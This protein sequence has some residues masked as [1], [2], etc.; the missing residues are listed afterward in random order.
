MIEVN[1]DGLCIPNNSEGIPCY[2][3][4]VKRDGRRVHS[5]Y[6]RVPTSYSKE[7]TNNVAEY[8]ALIRS[9]EWLK[10]NGY[11]SENAN[12]PLFQTRSD[13]NPTE[14][15]TIRGDSALI[16][17]QVNMKYKVSKVHLRPLHKRAMSL[18]SQFRNL[19]IIWVPRE[20]NSEADKLSEMAYA[21][22]IMRKRS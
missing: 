11:G 5:E 12:S 15:I 22:A 13:D 9:L 10:E 2:A 17:N 8:V 6:G 7:A 21:D 1:F 18:I 3:Y 20:E 19:K 4:L 16:I 14:E